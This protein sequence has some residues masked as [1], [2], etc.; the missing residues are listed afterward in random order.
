VNKFFLLRRLGTVREDT[1]H[2]L[3]RKK[4]FFVLILV[5]ATLPPSAGEAALV[6]VTGKGR[7][8]KL[9]SSKIRVLIN[10]IDCRMFS[11]L[12]GEPL[13]RNLHRNNFAL[14]S[15]LSLYKMTMSQPHES[16]PVGR[17]PGEGIDTRMAF[18]TPLDPVSTLSL[19]IVQPATGKSLHQ[20][21][22][23]HPR[24]NSTF[25]MDQGTFSICTTR[26]QRKKT[27]RWPIVG[28]RTQMASLF[29]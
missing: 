3:L 17:I 11:T 13:S 12:R 18:S 27:I 24:D 8:Q 1:K 25:L 22:I 4:V 20:R 23:K 19:S 21:K 16:V 2:S 6:V 7:C 14:H 28:R 9:G 29:S 26:W 5:L 15:H 10:L